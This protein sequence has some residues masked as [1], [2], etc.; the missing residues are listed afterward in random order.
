MDGAVQQFTGVD[1]VALRGLFNLGDFQLGVTADQIAM[2]SDL[3]AHL[4]VERRAVQNDQNAVLGF[5][6]L[7]GGDGVN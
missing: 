7:V 3:A 1:E 4:G 5:A 6:C 2:V